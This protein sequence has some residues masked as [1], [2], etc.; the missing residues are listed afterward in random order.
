MKYIRVPR[1]Y[2][3]L[4]KA[5]ETYQPVIFT[6]PCGQGK[7]AAV[8]YF[9]RRKKPLMLSARSG[10]IAGLDEVSSARQSIV[11]VD[12]LQ[13]LRD[14]GSIMDL[15]ALFAIPGI[16]V[17]LLTRGGI[18]WYLSAEEI[19]FSFVRIDE[20]DLRFGKE[21]VRSL[22]L[23]MG[24]SPEPEDISAIADAS[25]GYPVAVLYYARRMRHGEPYSEGMREAVWQDCFRYWDERF[26]EAVPPSF[27]EFG[28]AVC[29][30]DRFSVEMAETLTGNPKI[31]EELDFAVNATHQLLYLPDNHYVMREEIRRYFCW[32]QERI[33][34]KDKIL[35][36]YRVAAA[37]YEKEGDIASALRFF[38]EGEAKEDVKRLLIRN[39]KMHPGTA[40]YIETKDY[41]FSLP[42]EEI[43]KSSA[44]M[45]GMCML[46]DLILLPDDA[47]KWYGC[48][49]D[50][51]KNPGNTR[52]ERREAA[53][54]L[55]YL[56]IGLPH[57]GVK[58]I[59]KVMQSV[60][61]MM[62]KGE[63]VLPEMCATGNMPSI[64][65]GGLDF[66]EWSRHDAEIAKFMETPL[67]RLLGK[68][69]KGLVTIS[70]A[71]SGFEKG[72]M[73]SVEVRSRCNAGFEAASHGGKIEICFAAVGLLSKQYLLEGQFL[74]ARR[75]IDGFREKVLSENADF[76]LP[77][78]EALKIWL[79]LLA[80]GER[81][82]V[83]AYLAG[84]RDELTFFSI[85]D[86]Y[87][88]M[89]KLRCLIAEERY[90]EAMDL[91][92]FLTGYFEKYERYYFWMQN[93][94]LKGIILFRLDRIQWKDHVRSALEM[95]ADYHFTRLVALEGG[96]VLPLIH[97]LEKDGDLSGLPKDFLEAVIRE[98]EQ[99]AVTYPNYLFYSPKEQVELTKREAQILS[100]L[101]GGMTTEEI[102]REC[103][104]SYAGLKKHNRNLYRKLG[105]KNRAEAERRARHLGLIHVGGR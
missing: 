100:M 64:M 74:S 83:D 38:K 61:A 23:E 94:L 80:G 53:G 59:M 72:T 29:R 49:T 82:E 20:E 71:E 65:N 37:F 70:L 7:S 48:L 35:D 10:R 33:W 68:W 26:L 1:A 81:G 75:R 88:S 87:R 67:E 44:L 13:L 2:E 91:A 85:S 51:R 5:Q 79:V 55:A 84:T 76:L 60:F 34:E 95:A 52:E 3:K 14:E 77:N 57:K 40:H 47:E 22:F 96:A 28:L 45:A 12:D 104:I 86:R 41:Y 89:M 21:E 16:Q 39:A 31:R 24:L 27:R 56:D 54:W 73:D 46:C 42:E 105:A 78:L 30:Y 25:R 4:K 6:A 62:R 8:D 32:K 43:K 97:L 11:V 102:C 93:E 103:G 50:Y 15:R 58:G 9:Y 66:S 69:G 98:T 18:P 99:M 17:V 101:C 19:T 63:M 92:E 90:D 36:N